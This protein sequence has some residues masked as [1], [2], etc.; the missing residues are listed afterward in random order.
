[1][2]GAIT[3]TDWLSVHDASTRP[4]PVAMWIVLAVVAFALLVL[5]TT[6]N[7]TSTRLGRAREPGSPF[8]HGV[9]GLSRLHPD[10]EGGVA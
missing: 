3:A 8:M 10:E 5:A 4:Y 9:H 6:A 1:M 2:D 7:V